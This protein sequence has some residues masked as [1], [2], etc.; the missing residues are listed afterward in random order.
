MK[1]QH[2]P[3]LHRPDSARKAIEV[4]TA[5]LESPDG[6]PDLLLS[7]LR[8]EV[9]D[10]P[11]GDLY[12]SVSLIMGMIY[13]CESMLALREHETGITTGRTLRELGLKYAQA[14]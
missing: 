3:D 6:S 5:W 2:M 1:A 11:N 12:G 7:R 10:H 14:D 9:Q 4:M 8:A 13:L